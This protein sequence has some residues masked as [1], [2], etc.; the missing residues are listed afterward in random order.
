MNYP[1]LTKL[2]T[3]PPIPKRENNL[4]STCLPEEE[5]MIEPPVTKL[6]SHPFLRSKNY[7]YLDKIY[8]PTH[9]THPPYPPLRKEQ[10]NLPTPSLRKSI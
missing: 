10:N 6:P 4:P 3:Y 7:M 8:A 9:P 1:H 5:H 2:P